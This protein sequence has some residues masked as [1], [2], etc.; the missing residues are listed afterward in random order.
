M[1]AIFKNTLG[2]PLKMFCRVLLNFLL[3]FIISSLTLVANAS[4]TQSVKPEW[5]DEPYFIP[6]RPHAIGTITAMAQDKQGFLWLGSHY[7]IHRY[8]GYK[9]RIFSPNPKDPNA[10]SGG[11]I[12]DIVV[13]QSNKVWVATGANGLSVYSPQSESFDQCVT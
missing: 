1:R 12:K 7:D 11:Q 6:T 9:R 4:P 2:L 5:A 8:D 3:L 13:S 10:I